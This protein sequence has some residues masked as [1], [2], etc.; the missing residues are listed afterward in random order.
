[1]KDGLPWSKIIR[2]PLPNLKNQHHT[3][4]GGTLANETCMDN[5]HM[6]FEW[7]I[8]EDRRSVLLIFVFLR[9]RPFFLHTMPIYEHCDGNSQTR[10][11]TVQNWVRV[12]Y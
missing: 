12:G 6:S 7:M 4:V 9:R 11:L 1:M 8:E 3:L 5:V 10:R 2:I